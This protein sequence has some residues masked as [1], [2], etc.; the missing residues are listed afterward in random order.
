[1]NVI[2]DW[3]V[4][5]RDDLRRGGHARLANIVFRLP[6]AVCDNEHA[7]AD[8]LAEEGVAL[9]AGLELPWVELYLRHWALQ[10]RV[11]HRAEGESALGACVALVDFAHRPETRQCPQAV[12]S[13][14]DLCGCY[15]SVDGP[16][17]AA[18]RLAAAE[19]ALARIDPSW[20]CFACISSEKATALRQGGDAAASL[21]FLDAQ[22]AA[23]TLAGQPFP[24]HEMSFVRVAAL[25]QVGRFPEA[26]AF[27]DEGDRHGRQGAHA[28]V[29]RRL[30]RARVL[31]RTGRLADGARALPP[32][33]EVAGTPQFYV[34]YAD[35][36][37]L[38]VRGGQ[39]ENT[40]EV[41]AALARFVA[42]LRAQG[43]LRDTLQLA[44]LAGQLA[45][46]RGAPHV[47]RRH[48]A[49]MRD[50]ARRLRKPLDALDR[51]ASL[52]A[53][54]LDEAATA[55]PP[56]PDELLARL[57]AEPVDPERAAGLLDAAL[58]ACPDHAGAEAA[59]G[60]ALRELGLGEG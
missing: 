26:L 49:T 9:A 17:F 57:A 14:Q 6:Q 39:L 30:D 13:V 21:A 27:L 4:A 2:W 10:S 29:E 44:Q 38:L 1:M 8:A 51:I 41:G 40:W 35:A 3:V 16:G 43:V 37:G 7:V 52:A 18:E 31:A 42:R 55:Q 48:L 45:V 50:V 47:A 56:R 46:A 54:L 36:L 59:R 58:A 28:L 15:D 60:R 32:L 24:G 11:F 33:D 12:C 19:E 34:A 53:A 5:A 23:M 20:P 22:T 25:I